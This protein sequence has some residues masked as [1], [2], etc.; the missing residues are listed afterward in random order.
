[1]N[2][3]RSINIAVIATLLLVGSFLFVRA[4]TLLDAVPTEFRST[5]PGFGW[6]WDFNY[7][8]AIQDAGRLGSEPWQWPATKT[9][10]RLVIPIDQTLVSEGLEITYRGMTEPGAFRLDIV[11]QSLDSSV[12]Y[13]RDLGVA[14]AK[15]GFVIADHRFSLEKITPVYIRIQSVAR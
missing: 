3:D 1:M 13:P 4:I 2:S 5:S 8:T 9:G 6:S 15:R 12:S 7:E 14:E 10:N 11:I